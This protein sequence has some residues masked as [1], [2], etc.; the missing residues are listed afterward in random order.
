MFEYNMRTKPHK[1]SGDGFKLST[2]AIKCLT[3]I[4]KFIL[5][6]YNYTKL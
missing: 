1:I 3:L 4:P 5:L 2:S 6:F